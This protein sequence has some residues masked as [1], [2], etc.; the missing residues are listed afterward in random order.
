MP[1]QFV[2]S[3]WA[4]PLRTDPTGAIALVDSD[5]E[6]VESIRLVLGTAPGERPMRPE[7]GC[8]VHDYVFAPTDADTAG[9][10]SAEVRR[11]L[12]RWEP[13]VEVDSVDVSYDRVE[14]GTLYIDIRYTVRGTNNPRSLVFP[15]YVIPE[16]EQESSH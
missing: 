11:S 5:R 3:G 8:G 15:F 10:I 7:F 2:G 1:Q 14:T 9:R 16:H 4:F 13:R 6:I 12:D